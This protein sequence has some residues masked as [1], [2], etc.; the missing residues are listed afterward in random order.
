ML[1]SAGLPKRTARWQ[2]EKRAL[3][4]PGGRGHSEAARRR[5]PESWS[6]R[7]RR[8]GKSRRQSSQRCVCFGAQSDWSRS[9][10]GS[11]AGAALMGRA[12][13]M[14]VSSRVV[15]RSDWSSRWRLAS[16]KHSEGLAMVIQQH[17]TSCRRDCRRR[18]SQEEASAFQEWTCYARSAAVVLGVVAIVGGRPELAGDGDSK[19]LS[20]VARGWKGEGGGRR[21]G[22]MKR[23][24]RRREERERREGEGN[25]KRGASGSY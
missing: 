17:W 24:K 12:A 6:T 14:G 23:S 18:R 15:K 8:T 25:H 13:A 19:R 1:A 9:L 2:R 3:W 7:A 20:G 10:S 22:T 21:D 11:W 16:E 5:K 4:V